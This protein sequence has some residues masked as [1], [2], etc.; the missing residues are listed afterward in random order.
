[1]VVLW[2]WRPGLT[3]CLT[4]WYSGLAWS[5]WGMMVLLSTCQQ[6]NYPSPPCLLLTETMLADVDI[7]CVGRWRK[8]WRSQDEKFPGWVLIILLWPARPVLLSLLAAQGSGLIYT[9]TDIWHQEHTHKVKPPPVNKLEIFH[10][11]PTISVPSHANDHFL[12]TVKFLK[13]TRDHQQ[14][15][16]WDLML[17]RNVGIMC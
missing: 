5:K 14:H 3:C 12:W 6:Y 16:I 4:S 1:M 7:A 2:G 11:W 17:W 8:I 13:Y 15:Y 10:D 9:V